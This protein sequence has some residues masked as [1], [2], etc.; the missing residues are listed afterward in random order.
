MLGISALR[1]GYAWDF[2][3]W[4]GYERNTS[5]V[6]RN[7]LLFRTLRLGIQYKYKPSARNK[8]LFCT[9][10]LGYARSTRAVARYKV[11]FRTLRLGYVRKVSAAARNYLGFLTLRLGNAEDPCP[12]AG[13]YKEFDCKKKLSLCHKLCFSKPYI[14][15]FQCRRP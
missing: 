9:L 5:A 3:T 7:K 13:I 8:P 12:A 10:R 14:F 1:Q 4:V 6:A 15:G 2:C 11:L